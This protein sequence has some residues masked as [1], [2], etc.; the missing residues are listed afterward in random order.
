VIR[1]ERRPGQR[2]TERDALLLQALDWYEANLCPG[3]GQPLWESMDPANE[4]RYRVPPPHRCHACTEVD[5][6][7]KP[8][9][10][11]AADPETPLSAPG[12]LRFSAEL[13]PIQ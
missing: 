7:M 3:C 9:E 10:K 4:G 13:Q 1:S 6:A 11:A 5:L 2:W 12:A 8:F